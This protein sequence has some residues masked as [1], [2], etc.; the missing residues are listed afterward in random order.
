MPEDRNQSIAKRLLL[1]SMVF[2]LL[3]ITTTFVVTWALAYFVPFGVHA[4]QDNEPGYHA[5][6]DAEEEWA[7]I[8]LERPGKT[9]GTVVHP[10]DVQY[11]RL[12]TTGRSESPPPWTFRTEAGFGYDPVDEGVVDYAYGLPF[13]CLGYR[14]LGTWTSD[15]PYEFAG[16]WPT[17]QGLS[18]VPFRPILPGLVLNAAIY[19]GALWLPFT[20]FSR[21]RNHKRRS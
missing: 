12:E 20:V 2:F 9:F 21:I 5:Y 16:G 13:R 10:E 11:G 19:G 3:G 18:A 17:G 4:G 8:W 15:P 1:Q 6:F 7:Y 14:V